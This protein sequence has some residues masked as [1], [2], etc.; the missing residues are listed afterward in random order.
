MILYISI[1][2]TTDEGSCIAAETFGIKNIYWLVK[3]NNNAGTDVCNVGIE[4]KIQF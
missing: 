2:C 1:F 3:K 4:K